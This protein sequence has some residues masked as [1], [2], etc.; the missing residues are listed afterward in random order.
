MSEQSS[1]IPNLETLATQEQQLNERLA[2]NTVAASADEVAMYTTQASEEKTNVAQAQ[3]GRRGQL[4]QR[5]ANMA[6]EHAF[7]EPVHTEFVQLTP[8]FQAQ[9]ADT[10]RTNLVGYVAGQKSARGN[11]M[12]QQNPTVL[13]EHDALSGLDAFL[14]DVASLDDES[15]SSKYAAS[16]REGLTFIGE[17][18]YAQAVTAIA[19]DWKQ[20]L[21]KNPQLQICALAKMIDPNKIKSDSY[22]LD[23]ILGEYTDD[24]IIS[25]GNRLVV[26]VDKLIA[27]NEQVEVILVDDWTNSAAQ[28]GTAIDTVVQDYPQ[29]ANKISIQL[30]AAS[31]QR[32]AR[33]VAGTD[34]YREGNEVLVVPVSAYFQANKASVAEAHIT[35]SHGS[36]D[37][38]FENE[39]GDMAYALAKSRG[40]VEPVDLP[41][42]TNVARPYK[43]IGYRTSNVFRVRKL[44][45]QNKHI[46]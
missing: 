42:L 45:A 12:N 11:H 28:L 25:L 22:M 19:E 29:Y 13:T 4:I 6:I 10:S 43:M 37:Y 36:M 40:E 23:S 7:F 17:R 27:G 16:M 32:L 44:Q 26:D 41:P 2:S 46:T 3:V 24:E 15:K 8:S 38:D 35:G 31:K 21:A 14:A 39:F 20:K 1:K 18:E 34:P 30:I 5:S 33:G 9:V